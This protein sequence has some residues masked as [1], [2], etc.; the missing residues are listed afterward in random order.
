M[1]SAQ[2][3]A[4]RSESKPAR[5]ETETAEAGFRNESVITISPLPSGQAMFGDQ[6]LLMKDAHRAGINFFANR[7]TLAVAHIASV[8]VRQGTQ[9]RQSLP[10]PALKWGLPRGRMYPTVGFAAPAHRL[11]VQFR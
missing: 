7:Y 4:L 11:S 8:V 6:F 10:R 3:P 2:A 9:G 1:A 5:E